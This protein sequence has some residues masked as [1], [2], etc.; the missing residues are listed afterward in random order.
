MPLERRLKHALG[1]LEIWLAGVLPLHQTPPAA[2]VVPPH[3]PVIPCPRG[4]FGSGRDSRLNRQSIHPS[5]WLERSITEFLGPAFCYRR[6]RWDGARGELLSADRSSFFFLCVCVCKLTHVSV[7]A[8]ARQRVC[9]CELMRVNVK[10]MLTKVTCSVRLC[11]SPQTLPSA[12]KA[13]KNNNLLTNRW[14]L[15]GA[16]VSLHY[17]FTL[18]VGV[19]VCDG[20]YKN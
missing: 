11:M 7:F 1:G 19:W 15:K 12:Q 14:T 16:F 10:Q 13:Q 17:L 4:T 9:M 18:R 3:P 6:T 5:T 8:W 20:G 2:T